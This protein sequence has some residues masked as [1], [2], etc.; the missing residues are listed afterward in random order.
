MSCLENTDVINVDVMS[1]K[2]TDIRN[3]DVLSEKTQPVTLVTKYS[4]V[5]HSCET[6]L[7]SNKNT[8]LVL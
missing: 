7:F 2:N 6:I 1:E 5:I 8:L 4:N 3:V